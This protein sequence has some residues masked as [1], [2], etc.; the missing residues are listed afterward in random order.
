MR[1]GFR[2]IVALLAVGL[3][4][5]G[6]GGGSPPPPS[7]PPPPP[8]NVA[9]TVANATLTTNEDQAGTVQVTASDANGDLLS[10]VV[11][12]DPTKGRVGVTGINPF[13]FTYTPHANE[14]GGDTIGFRVSDGRGGT[15]DA[16]I[17]VT[18]TPQPDDPTFNASTFSIDEDEEL[19][20]NVQ[21]NDPDGETITYAVTVVPNIG[22]ITMNPANGAFTYTPGA[23][24]HGTDQ[25]QTRATSGGVSV[26]SLTTIT[27]AAVNDA[28]TAG[29]DHAIVGPPPYPIPVLLNDLD[30]DGDPLTISIESPTPG[31]TAT[32]AGANIEITPVAGM[33]GPTSFTYRV[34]DPAGAFAVGTVRMLVGGA[35]NFFYLAPTG[36][37]DALEIWRHDH[38]NSRRALAPIPAGHTLFKFTSSLNGNVLAY[39]TYESGTAGRH[40]LWVKDQ[41]D[42]AQ[43]AGQV[44]TPNNY[45]TGN[46]SLSSSGDLLIFDDRVVSTADPSSPQF[47]EAGAAVE[48]PVFVP[49]TTIYYAV[50][51]PGGGRV[52]KRE[53]VA[54]NGVPFNREQMTA[55]YNVAEGLGIDFRLTPNYARI[56]STGL[57]FPPPA[58]SNSIKQNAFVT[59]A[60]GQRMDTKLHPDFTSAVDIALQPWVTADSTHAVYYATLGGVSGLYSTDL[61]NWGTAVRLMALAPNESEVA[62]HGNSSAVFVKGPLYWSRA[63]VGVANT[64]TPFTPSPSTPFIV[65]RR[66]A[67]APDG[68]DVVFDVGAGIYATMGNQFT[69]GTLLHT[70][71]DGGFPP[72][73][74]YSPDSTSV[75]VVEP[76][77]TGSVLVNPRAIGWKR[78]LEPAPAVYSNPASSCIAYAGQGC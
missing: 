76:A 36:P 63:T 54:A 23:N 52:I 45:H 44:N 9:P 60:D 65:P 48:K 27:I 26:T 24:L 70:R 12:T 19:F 53:S 68:H 46:L 11:T 72:L 77:S 28:P 20:G 15:A 17:A 75:A 22:T 30:V 16:T 66:V 10:L 41:D 43:P 39:T 59:W 58:V 64:S 56:V 35:Q 69:T 50:V 14:Y 55:D 1:R 34:T 29:E 40:W 71:A 4:S 78:T 62:L 49:N 51:Q 25:F 61:G 2:G 47:I 8:P 5:C 57:M 37:G 38:F 74:Y 33:K 21:A 13:T 73:L 3:V 42:P 6:G 32:V 67:P 18:I 31:V 7:P